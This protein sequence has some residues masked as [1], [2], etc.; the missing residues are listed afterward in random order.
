M[1]Q[2][3]YLNDGIK[4]GPFTLEQL[5]QWPTSREI[6]VDTLIW[7]QGISDWTPASEL[8]EFHSILGM[9]A[10][11]IETTPPDY[12]KGFMDKLFGGG[13]ANS[14]NSY[15]KE[16]A[17]AV[18]DQTETS[19]TKPL[20]KENSKKEEFAPPP[21]PESAKESSK[22]VARGWFK[23]GFVFILMSIKNTYKKSF[24]LQGRAPVL[25][26]WS[27]QLFYWSVAIL[28]ILK[29]MSE[30]GKSMSEGEI[31]YV[32]ALGL[33]VIGSI[34]AQ[35]SL[36][37]RRLHDLGWSGWWLLLNWIP[38]VGTLIAIVTYC[39][40]GTDGPNKYDAKKKLYEDSFPEDA[41]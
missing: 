12:Q 11:E 29:G 27:F 14:D 38:V 24:T 6:E 8:A 32:L 7:F 3:F 5:A 9:P 37:V 31:P 41:A 23:T 34:P 21:I 22:P 13:Q 4:Q 25:E 16:L 40:P 10:P 30:A 18:D 33:F 17:S 19:R 28:L 1:Q 15:S 36:L 26:F 2:Y 35:F 20:N 39:F